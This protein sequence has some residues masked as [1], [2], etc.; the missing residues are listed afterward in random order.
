M[1]EITD[2]DIEY[3]NNLGINFR[4]VL[5][6]VCYKSNQENPINKWLLKLDSQV[7]ED[8]TLLLDWQDAFILNGLADEIGEKLVGKLIGNKILSI[9]LKSI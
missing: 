7:Q 8:G 3:F 5:E 2:G 9:I 6:I 4:E 1:I